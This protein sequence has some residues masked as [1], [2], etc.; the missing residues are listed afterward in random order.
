MSS[1]S[2]GLKMR[3]FIAVDWGTTNFR[4]F[5]MQGNGACLDSVQSDQGVLSVQN[6]D[7]LAVIVT[8][9]SKWLQEDSSLP[10]IMS[11]MV[12]SKVGWFDVPY[13]ELPFD[14]SALVKGAHK[15]S[16]DKFNI[17]I[18][19]GVQADS[20]E[21]NVDVMR[22]EE[23]QVI[24]AQAIAA[25]NQLSYMNICL[26]GTHSKWLVYRDGH[27]TLSTF[28]TGELFSLLSQH[29][30]L[31]RTLDDPAIWSESDFNRGVADS[32]QSGLGLLHNLFGVRTKKLFPGTDS[33]HS[34]SYLSGLLI[35]AEIY[36][37]LPYVR[38]GLV[39][40]AA[41]KLLTLYSQ[42]FEAFSCP[43][44]AID[45]NDATQMGLIS[46]FES[47]YNLGEL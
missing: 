6:R 14:S 40:V 42:A 43:V 3:R 4:A 1:F 28:M 45:S 20:L 46:I 24:G 2:E 32:A 30:I 16:V 17:W 9:L 22:G 41:S 13:V 29:S 47:I 25:A 19:P 31:S 27:L 26:P 23:V 36:P 35:G 8:N 44:L 39:V 34:Q 5:L 7:F 15:V 21:G 18:I 38:S 10:I 33:L 11:G 12:G 37:M